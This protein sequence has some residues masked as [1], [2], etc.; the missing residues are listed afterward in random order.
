MRFC[1]AEPNWQDLLGYE[2]TNTATLPIGSGPEF[3]RLVQP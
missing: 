1:I 2:G 3:F